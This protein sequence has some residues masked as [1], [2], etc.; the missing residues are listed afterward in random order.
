M[1]DENARTPT[2]DVYKENLF[3]LMKSFDQVFVV[4][5][6]LDECKQDEQD[7]NLSREQI[8]NFVLDLTDNLPCAKVFV[9]SRRET[10]IRD[11]FARHKSLTIE[12]EAKCVTEDIKAYVNDCVEYLVD[13]KKLRLRKLSLKR[14]IVERLVVGAEGM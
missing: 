7:G 6:A 1:Y 5:D 3:H 14:D 12:I 2:F 11:A 9:T 8:M 4:L 10:D 13:T